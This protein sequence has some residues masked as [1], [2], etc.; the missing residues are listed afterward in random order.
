MRILI[1]IPEMNCGGAEK[2]AA[3][4]A[5]YF[6]KKKLCTVSILVYGNL[7]SAYFLDERIEYIKINASGKELKM[8][9][10]VAKKIRK[11]IIERNFDVV[12]GF[13]I[14]VSE[15]LPFATKGLE[16]K[17]VGSE[18]SNPKTR[19]QSQIRRLLSNILLGYLDG[20]IF[21]TEGCRN[22]YSSLVKKKSIVIPNGFVCE[23]NCEIDYSYRKTSRDIIAVGNLRKI[24]DYPTMIQAFFY[25]S[26]K[27]T[28]YKL[29]IYGDG[30]EKDNIKVLIDSF[31]LSDRIF[32]HGIVEDLTE[33][34]IRSCF[35]IHSSLS[36]SWCNAILEAL[37][38]GVPCIAAD[39]DFGPREMIKQGYNGFLYEPTNYH[40]LAEY[41]SVLVDDKERISGMS[42]NAIDSAKKFE[43]SLIAEQ[44]YTYL[45]G[46]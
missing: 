26:K 23:N 44:Y 13:S 19:N 42:Q 1:I 31:G 10:P 21:I 39:C 43:F 30:I 34:Y 8:R 32:I 4:L 5:N 33:V 6:I 36:E 20:I 24:K 29:H 38:F 35:L 46:V 9:L 27:H 16:C 2:I 18:R 14:G 11:I 28:D 41:M 3:N 7:E 15:I 37:S 12:L 25:F 22:Y 45:T 40:Q 17:V